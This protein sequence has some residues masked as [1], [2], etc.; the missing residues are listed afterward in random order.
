MSINY[1]NNCYPGIVD[2]DGFCFRY[3]DKDV[4]DNE[5]YLMSNYWREQINTYGQKVTYFVNAYN[6]LSADNIYGEHPTKR[7]APGR[8]VVIALQLSENAYTL[9]KFGFQSDDEI[10]AFIHISTFYDAFWDLNLKLIT[11]E[12]SGQQIT[13]EMGDQL[14]TEDPSLFETQ[15][16]QVEPKAGDVFVMS[17]YGRGRPGNRSGIQF[18]ITEVLD[19]DVSQMNQLGGHYVWMLKAKRFDFSFEPGLS[20]E[21]GSDQVFD[22]SFNG[23]LSGGEQD[24][25]P[26]RKY[27]EQHPLKNIDEV[28][29]NVV[30]DM[31]A[32]DN[33]DVYGDY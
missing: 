22:S 17:E 13:S 12:L 11:T 19:Q 31:P 27:E 33:T 2:S 32:N 18:E 23:I 24:K 5:Q 10:T 9:S 28:S 8:E 1:N 3:N 21:R 29:K 20:A 7:F 26:D 30:F 6:V 15:Y 25:S 14:R 16:N 4:N